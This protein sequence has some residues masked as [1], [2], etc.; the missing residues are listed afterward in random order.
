MGG[1]W[2]VRLGKPVDAA[3]AG[4]LNAAVQQALDRIDG[5]MSTWNPASGLS[6]FNAH[7]GTD[8]F[9]VPND[10]A[11]VVAEAQQVAADTGGAFD[12]T[13]GPLVN[14][15]GFGPGRPATGPYKALSDAEIEAARADVGYHLLECRRSP[16]AVR[17]RQPEVYV[18]LSAIAQGYAADRV[19]AD[20]DAAGVTD[21]LVEVCGEMRAR[22]SSP[23]GRPWRVGI[24]TP[25]PDVRRVL[26]T[27]ELQDLSLATSGDYRNV[28]V[29]AAGRRYSHAIDPRTG[30]PAANGLASVSVVHES[31]ARAD[32][33]ATALMVLG[34]DDGYDLARR[35]GLAALFVV[36]GEGRFEVRATP[37]FE[38]VLLPEESD[39]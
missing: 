38:R 30:R 23:L 28:R 21:Y 31:A 11:A 25:T 39:P 20:L 13:I 3:V 2:S 12:V 29:D 17:K 4:P 18:D 8:W 1:T 36:R 16:P 5:Q 9:V 6:R 7:R 33:S 14:L 34:P 15:W 35:S 37:E 24:E 19:A 10:L 27:V 26:R 22:G 32:A